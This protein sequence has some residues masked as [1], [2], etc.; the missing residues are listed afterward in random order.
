M[1]GYCYEFTKEGLNNKSVNFF[2]FFSKRINR[3][4]INPLE[5]EYKWFCINTLSQP[6]FIYFGQFNRCLNLKL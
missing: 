4:L 6:T 2:I 5:K 1:Y 3:I